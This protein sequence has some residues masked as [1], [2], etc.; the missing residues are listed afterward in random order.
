MTEAG[1]YNMKTSVTEQ[2]EKVMVWSDLKGKDSWKESS[3]NI[4]REICHAILPLHI[5]QRYGAATQVFEQ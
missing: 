3:F 5:E 4:F 1:S 2:K